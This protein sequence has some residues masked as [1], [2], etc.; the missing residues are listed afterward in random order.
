MIPI[1]WTTLA[2]SESRP[3][4]AALSS[5]HSNSA[6][7]RASILL[8]PA[9][10]LPIL[11]PLAASFTIDNLHPS[12]PDAILTAANRLNLFA[13][14]GLPVD[15]THINAIHHHL[16]TLAALP[17]EDPLDEPL[18]LDA[19]FAALALDAFPLLPTFT[20]QPLPTPLPH[21]PEYQIDSQS[22]IAYLASA[23]TSRASYEEVEPTWGDHLLTFPLKLAAHTTDWH[24][25]LCAA[26]AVFSGCHRLDPALVAK[27]LHQ[28]IMQAIGAGR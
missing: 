13:T 24:Y 22:F 18:F 23:I 3:A 12:N 27:A 4:L 1:T 14:H 19:A 28:Q 16:S 9:R 17:I 11:T 21:Q 2:Q 26:R 7:A 25:L 8:G 5:D 6:L 10:I 15:P 20:A